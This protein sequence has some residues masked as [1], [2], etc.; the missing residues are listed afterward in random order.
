MASKR[1]DNPSSTI[2]A[3]MKES[4]RERLPSPFDR[5][6]ICHVST[7]SYLRLLAVVGKKSAVSS[8]VVELERFLD[9]RQHCLVDLLVD[10]GVCWFRC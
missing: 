7:P 8:K 3:E 6:R 1:K 5:C 2:A 9:G 10:V 4:N